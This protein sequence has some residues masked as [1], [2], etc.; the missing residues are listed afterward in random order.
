MAKCPAC[1]SE[2]LPADQYKGWCQACVETLHRAAIEANKDFDERYSEGPDAAPPKEARSQVGLKRVAACVACGLSYG[3]VCVSDLLRC[4][5]CGQVK[6]LYSTPDAANM[7]IEEAKRARGEGAT[8]EV[9]HAPV[10]FSGLYVAYTKQ[11]G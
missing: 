5:Q 10:D 7:A 6:A 1:D 4:P 8:C 11:E 2:V 3:W 9:C